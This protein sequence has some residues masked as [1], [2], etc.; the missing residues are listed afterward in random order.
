M[1]RLLVIS[2]NCRYLI[3]LFGFVSV[4]AHAID[5]TAQRPLN[6]EVGFRSG[7]PFTNLL[8]SRLTG[9]AAAFSSATFVK[10]GFSVG[11]TFGV[12]LHDQIAIEFDAI[13]RPIRFFG[14]SRTGPT[15]QSLSTTRGSSWEFPL[16]VNYRF[17][18]RPIRPF[19]GGGILVGATLDGTT[20]TRTLDL[21]TGVESFSTGPFRGSVENLGPALVV[22]GGLEWRN[23]R[24]LIRPELRYTRRPDASQNTFLFRAPNQFEYLIGF[25]FLGRS[26]GDVRR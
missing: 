15:L 12:I 3:T 14:S 8:S 26:A 19:G 23:S 6:F 17:F 25:S 20:E 13:Y 16:L 10:P 21:Q 2:M 9:V 1:A 24:F 22:S 18:R 4:L 7:V 5:G 11:P